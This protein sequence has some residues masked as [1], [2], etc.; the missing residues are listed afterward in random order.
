MKTKVLLFFTFLCF[1][2]AQAQQIP[3]ISL[4]TFETGNESHSVFGHTAIR[5]E[6]KAQGTDLVYNFGVFDFDTPYFLAKFSTG[7]LDYKL[8]IQDYQAT[9]A[10]YFSA[11]RQIYEQIL[12]LDKAQTNQLIN[13]L[14][15]LHQ[16]EN[17]Y[18]RYRFLSR[19]CSTEIRDLLFEEIKA[20]QYTPKETR[21]TFRNYLDDY[22]RPAPWF[23]F[24]INLA[25]GSSIDQ[26]INTY[27]L[28]FLPDYLSSEI[29]KASLNEKPLA[30]KSTKTFTHLK[31]VNENKWKL[32]PFV[33]FAF[34]F[35]VM[36]FGK[37]QFLIRSYVFTTGLFGV[38]IL[39]I[40][41]FSEHPE[42]LKN[43]NL[44]WLNPLYLLIFVL[45][46]TSLKTIRKTVSTILTLCLLASLGVWFSK[47]Q[48]YDITFF[49]IL[50]TL[51]WINL[52][53]SQKI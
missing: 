3:K 49:P 41:L 50:I 20:T 48:G 7:T 15:Y 46:F 33:V 16:P 13:K 30:Q 5:I 1:F 14:K 6:D 32:S 28:M 24:G 38:L 4:L 34:I 29:S 23:K 36:V 10:Y 17:R 51:L 43:Y 52:R 18:Y 42:V 9:L 53:Q 26:N 25:L 37:S 40:N 12:N 11:N 21:R 2:F 39:I 8:G 27:N 47:I 19:N 35:I 44:L 22:T 31:P 45:S